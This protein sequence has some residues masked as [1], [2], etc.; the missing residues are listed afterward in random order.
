M[1]WKPARDPEARARQ[2]AD[3]AA[4]PASR[5]LLGVPPVSRTH[6]RSLDQLE[7]SPEAAGLPRARV[8]RGRLRAARRDQPPHVLTLLGASV[9]LAGLAA[10][11]RPEE[12]IV[13]YVE[14]P[15]AGRPRRPALLRHHDARR[16]ERLRPG[17]GEPRGPPHEDRGQRAPPGDA[18]ARR[19]RACRRRSSTSTTRTAR[20]SVLR[21]GEQLDAGPSSSTAWQERAK[22]HAADGGEGLAVLCAALGLADPLPPRRGPARGLPARAARG[23]RPGRRDERPRGDRLARSGGRSSRCTAW[24]RR[25]AILAV[26]ADF[27]H[28]D[29]EMIR[30]TRGFA[31]GRRVASP[32][33][34]MSRL[35]A[36]EA[37]F[38]VTGANADHRAASR[39]APRPGLRR[40]ARSPSCKRV[41]PR[42]RGPRRAGGARPRPGVPARPRR[43]PPGPPGGVARPRRPAAAGRGPRGRARAER[44]PRQ[45]R[46]ARSSTTSRRTRCSPTAGASASSPEPWRAAR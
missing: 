9:S 19:A 13:P 36:V 23:P 10:C 21:R 4:R 25:R 7:G 30:N 27:L 16:D 28:A 34:T 29:P 46:D 43:R 42:A 22:V 18:S 31:A 45:R 11:R 44:R 15:G 8:P 2:L 20:R 32:A 40:R 26:D 38:S 12:H 24:R 35:W 37:A 17:G 6:W 41:R 1:A 3:A 39:R 33:D 14:R 5:R